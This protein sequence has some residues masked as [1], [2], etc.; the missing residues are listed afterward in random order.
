MGALITI[1]W[2]FANVWDSFLSTQTSA[3]WEPNE[4]NRL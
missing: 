3:A 4:L 1:I 2:S